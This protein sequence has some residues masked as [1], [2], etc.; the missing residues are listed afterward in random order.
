LKVAIGYGGD[1]LVGGGSRNVNVARGEL[2][3]G[4]AHRRVREVD[5]RMER[6]HLLD[7]CVFVGRPRAQQIPFPQRHRRRHEHVA[8]RARIDPGDERA[9][10]RV[11]IV[12]DVRDARGIDIGPGDENVERAAQCDDLRDRRLSSG[13]ISEAATRFPSLANVSSRVSTLTA[14]MTAPLRT[15]G[16][17]AAHV[18]EVGRRSTRAADERYLSL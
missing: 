8:A 15:A 4:G 18:A 6:A 14:R 2:Q 7:V 16:G 11:E 13:R 10:Y 1:K 17:L 12:A 9:V 3:L 5:D